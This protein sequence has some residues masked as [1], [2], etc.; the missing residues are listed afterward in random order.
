[1]LISIVMNRVA[2]CGV[3]RPGISRSGFAGHWTSLISAELARQDVVVV[4]QYLEGD[5]SERQ[6]EPERAGEAG[7]LGLPGERPLQQHAG[8]DEGRRLPSHQGRGNRTHQ[9]PAQGRGV[10]LHR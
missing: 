10:R 2:R 1:M 5:E 9:E 6:S 8:G 4:L 7:R 3:T